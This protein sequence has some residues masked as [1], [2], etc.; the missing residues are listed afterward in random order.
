MNENLKFM[1]EFDE[2]NLPSLS[3]ATLGALELFIENG[4]P[5][6]EIKD[7]KK[8]VI[9]GSGN[10][11]VTAGIL[12]A[13]KDVIFADENNYKE[14]MNISGVDG[15]LVFSASGAKHGPIIAQEAINKG[16]KCQVITCTPDSP[17]EKIVGKENTILTVKNREPY[18]Y[19]TST[20][21]GWIFAKTREDPKYILDFILNEVDK[22]IPKNI[23]NYLGYLLVSPNEYSKGNRLFEV[24]FIELFA[25]RIARD[26]KTYEELKHAVTVVP[27][28]KELCIKF[29]E[30]DVDFA[31]DV[32]TIPLPEKMGPAAMMAIGYYV[33]GKIAEGKEQWFKKN[34]ASYI[35]RINDEGF[36]RGMKVIVE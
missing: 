8:P 22:A 24:K 15:V 36:G 12:Y 16:L 18:T 34:I 5:E 11:I 1:R 4:L 9:V 35:K 33:I 23:S 13:G 32:I 29:G 17:A 2:S 26:V 30:G 28:E 19:N 10:A 6:V 3:V 21:M 7:F 25:R 27:Y 20:Y 31:N 14:A